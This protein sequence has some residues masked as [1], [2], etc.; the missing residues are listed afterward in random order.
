M[1]PYMPC[2][3]GLLPHPRSEASG[4][5]T[6]LVEVTVTVP[7]IPL[8]TAASGSS[9][10]VSEG[11]LEPPRPMRALGPQPS[12]SAYSATPTWAARAGAEGL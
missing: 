12:A 1:S 10:G 4:Q 5:P 7:W 11:G 8:V 3:F 9:G 6:D 2:S